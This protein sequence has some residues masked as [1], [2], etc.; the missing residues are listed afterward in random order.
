MQQEGNDNLVEAN[1]KESK[2]AESAFLMRGFAIKG[3]PKEMK[4]IDN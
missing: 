1:A 4:N 2:Q 3:K